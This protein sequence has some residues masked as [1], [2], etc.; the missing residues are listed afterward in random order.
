M[1]DTA[2]VFVLQLDDPVE[3]SLAVLRMFRLT[4]MRYCK[5]FRKELTT[6]HADGVF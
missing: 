5:T 2:D 6:N 3:H 4:V 1:A